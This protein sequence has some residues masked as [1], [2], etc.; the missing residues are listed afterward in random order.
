MNQNILIKFVVSLLDIYRENWSSEAVFG[1][2]KLGLLDF[3][4]Y[5]ICLLENYCKKWGIKG[6]KW[7]KKE[8]SYEP[9]NDK[10][11]KF[12]QMRKMII[13]P[14]L[15]FKTNFSDTKNAKEIT[16]NIYQF[17]IENNVIK[18]LD[19]KIQASH[20]IEI[21]NEYNTSYK[22]LL[23][24]FDEIVLLFGEEKI[25]FDKYKELLTVGISNCELGKIPATQQQ[26]VFGDVDRTRN[27]KIKVLFVLGMNDGV[28]QAA[29]RQEGYLN[30][31]DREMLK[32]AGIELSKTS[33]ENVYE[34]QFNIY[35]TLTL[36]EEKLFLS[37]TSSD[38]EGK[39]IRPSIV[40]KKIKRYFPK[41]LEKSD[42]VEKE[43]S[44]TNEKATF[45][46]ALNVYYNY[47]ENG[48]IDEKWKEILIYFNMKDENKFQ[49]A[50]SGMNYTNQA[51]EIDL[52][53]IQKIY[54]KN[55]TT[56]ISKLETYRRCPFSFHMTYGLKLKETENFQMTTLDTGSFMHEVIDLF[57]E[58][59]EEN[60]LDLKSI[61]D[62]K[63]EEIVNKIINQILQTSRYYI[64]TSSAKFK[65][66]TR[67]LKKVVLESMYYII[68]SL[69]NSDFITTGHEIEFNKNGKYKPIK[70]KLET[71]ENVEIEG[72][73]DRVDI[74]K[75]DDKNY[76]RIIDYKSQIKK[77]DLNQVVS[78]LQIQLLTYLDALTEE[79][80][81]EPAGVLY[82]GLIDNIIKSSKNLSEEEISSKI[83]KGFKMQGL[84]LADVNIVKMMDKTLET[85]GS[86]IVPAYIG[87]EGTL[88]ASRSSI[89]TREE[90][91]KLQKKV[92]EIIK[93]IS[94]EILNGK[95]DIK[96]YNYNKKT[97]CDYCQ[98]KE[99]CMFNPNIKGNEYNYIRKKDSFEILEEL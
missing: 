67:R 25:G 77:L 52:E 63:V 71:G 11:E 85:G 92:K 64:F 60:D 80:D 34:S 82:L 31:N 69:K 1:Y 93:D 56:T 47:L 40:I 46:D 29:N 88:S 37:Y 86:D 12:E 55:M 98:Y 17:L 44:I 61:S 50:I 94:K 65:V 59:L 99:I 70:M 26:V 6:S 68:Y 72:K 24:I 79:S 53:N 48:K 74:G 57:F 36:P 73:I 4:Y 62:E 83:K 54:G 96:P 3:E 14:L 15:D 10:Q 49:K 8:F 22:I 91:E 90:F 18:N 42:I 28:F 5:D 32:N 76:V 81:L 51:E 45:E 84:I 27:N 41:I 19:K 89:A 78:G 39:T 21:S 75:L 2:L 20:S 66:M 38:R 9:M 95:I 87:K 30:D 58:Y 7:Y 23:Q 35:R 16:K 33:I 13:K 97:G 43:Y